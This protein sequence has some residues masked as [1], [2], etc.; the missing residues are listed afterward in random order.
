MEIGIIGLP[1]VG[2]STLFNALTRGHAAASNYPFTTIDPNIGIT[3]V[4]D[5][6]L[7]L[8]ASAYKSA[9]SAEATIKFVDIAGLVAGA[10][11]GEGL[12]NKFLSHIR[13]MDALV[14]VVRLFRDQDVVH[15]SGDI[16]PKGD[17][18][19]IN[20]ELLLADLE[21]VE[22]EMEKLSGAARTGIALAKERLE[23]L[24][25][26]KDKL[27]AGIP[28]RKCPDVT[29]GPLNDLNLLT[30]KPVLFAGNIGEK[31]SPEDETRI[32]ILQ[33]LSE[34]ENAECI[35][36]AAKLETEVSELPPD[37]QNDFRNE[38]LTKSE[39]CEALI[40][41]AYRLLRLITFFT[42]NANEARAW[43][44]RDNF[45]AFQAAGKIHSD[46]QKGFIRADVYSYNDLAKSGSEPAVREAGLL[47]SEGKDY[48]VQDGDIIFF[49]FRE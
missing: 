6:R 22:R 33:E 31:V 32:T 49:K 25:H 10:S 19:T 24:K 42:A 41:K 7:K 5:S 34:K 9:K 37:I 35:L 14:H 17:T 18:E 38:I 43:P 39:G 45:T 11:K 30:A 29:N 23:A 48:K 3:S 27:N 28:A 15:V 13:E 4:P 26:I 36:F 21:T 44:I 1:N 40:T 12:G 16:N 8:V 20:T 47:R 2:K 46:I